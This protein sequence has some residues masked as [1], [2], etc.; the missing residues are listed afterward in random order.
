MLF[1]LAILDKCCVPPSKSPLLRFDVS[2]QTT[3]TK[4]RQMG[5]LAHQMFFSLIFLESGKSKIMAPAD[6]LCREVRLAGS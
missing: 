4:F 2:V 5:R 1:N 6:S 3:I